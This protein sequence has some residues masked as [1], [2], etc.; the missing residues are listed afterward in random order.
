[1]WEL[2]FEYPMLFVCT[3]DP[4][5]A[6]RAAGGVKSLFLLTRVSRHL[7]W[8]ITQRLMLRTQTQERHCS[9]FSWQFCTS[10]PQLLHL[11][12]EN[13]RGYNSCRTLMYFL[14]SKAAAF[15]TCQCNNA[16]HILCKTVL[17]TAYSPN[18]E[19]WTWLQMN[20]SL[21]V[22]IFCS[23]FSVKLQLPDLIKI[24][25]FCFWLCVVIYNVPRCWRDLFCSVLSQVNTR[26]YLLIYW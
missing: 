4:E 22:P 20:F 2:W 21:H 26:G 3:A 23:V 8:D 25:A 24:S 7:I 10:N 13:S 15:T 6:V 14:L 12:N 1:M 19:V 17:D 18:Q 9:F 5:L 11:G 16:F